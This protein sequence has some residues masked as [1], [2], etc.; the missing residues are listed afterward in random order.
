MKNIKEIKKTS[1]SIS[2][3]GV[4]EGHPDR[5]CDIIANSILDAHLEDDPNTKMKVNVM[6]KTNLVVNYLNVIG[7][8]LWGY[9]L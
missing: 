2:A 6:I 8:N 9:K 3:E 1:F 5:L 7:S 4:T